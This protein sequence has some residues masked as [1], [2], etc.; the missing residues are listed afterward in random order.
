MVNQETIKDWF[1]Q[2]N[3]KHFENQITLSLD[4]E[5]SHRKVRGRCGFFKYPRRYWLSGSSGSDNNYK[6]QNGKIVVFVNN[7][8]LQTENDVKETLLHEMVHSYLFQYYG[9]GRCGHTPSFKIK[10]RNI[11]KN[12]F[13]DIQLS[14]VRFKQHLNPVSK[15]V[16][17]S[18]II[19]TMP[20]IQPKT[21]SVT[22]KVISTGKVGKFVRE[23][24]AYGKKHITLQIEGCMF[25][26]TTEFENVIKV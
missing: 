11:L 5:V 9:K 25:P 16:T 26:F 20:V 14:N 1:Q 23:S 8:H 15:E 12:E 3:E 2:L 19:P 21:D 24:I 6:M 18:N 22:F 17:V 13:G 10:L 7:P 4:V